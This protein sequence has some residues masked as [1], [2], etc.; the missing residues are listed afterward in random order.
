MPKNTGTEDVTILLHYRH[1]TIDGRNV[2]HHIFVWSRIPATGKKRREN[3]IDRDVTADCALRC[4]AP[5]DPAS[6]ETA[7]FIVNRVAVLAGHVHSAMG[8]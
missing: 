1:T 8:Y 5:N 3:A 6:A 4:T 2:D 7:W